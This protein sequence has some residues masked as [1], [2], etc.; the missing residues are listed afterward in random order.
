VTVDEV[1]AAVV[2][3]AFAERDLS[4]HALMKQS[5]DDDWE[6]ATRG[7][8]EVEAFV[9]ALVEGQ[10]KHCGCHWVKD[11]GQ[12]QD[13]VVEL[14]EL[15]ARFRDEIADSLAPAQAEEGRESPV[16]F[17]RMPEC[18]QTTV[19]F[20]VTQAMEDAWNEGEQG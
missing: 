2:R 14:E 10:C 7:K 9:K 16:N 6:N 19:C 17:A 8:M 12:I 5:V 15:L 20:T 1:M 4:R 11:Y 18:G 13:R 3:Y